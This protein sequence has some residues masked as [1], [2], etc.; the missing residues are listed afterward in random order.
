MAIPG[1]INWNIWD[2]TDTILSGGTEELVMQAY[3]GVISHFLSDSSITYV[4]L[5]TLFDFHT[6]LQSNRSHQ[7]L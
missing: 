5:P 4:L 2:I 6:P 1:K 3:M 7:K